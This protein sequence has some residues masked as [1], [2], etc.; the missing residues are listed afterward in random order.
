[1]TAH[2][3]NAVADQVLADVDERRVCAPRAQP[4]TCVSRASF[5]KQGGTDGHNVHPEVAE[6]SGRQGRLSKQLAS[7]W[8]TCEVAGAA[9]HLGS[10]VCLSAALWA[11]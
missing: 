7:T 4:V 5:E 6:T 2:L 9:A 8:N 10:A 3:W 11:A 1:M